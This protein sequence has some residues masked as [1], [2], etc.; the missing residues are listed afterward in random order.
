MSRSYDARRKAKRQQARIAREGATDARSWHRPRAIAVLPV[1]AIAAVLGTVGVLGFGG[2]D[3]DAVDKKEIQQ[4]VSKLLAGIPQQGPTLGSP[5]APITVW[6]LADL[7][8][9][10]VR[11]FAESYLPSILDTWVRTGEV[12]LTY[13]SLQTDTVDEEVFYRH[14]IAALAAGRQDKMWN[15]A[16]AFVHQQGE[17]FTEYATDE[18]LADLAS[19]VPGLTREQWRRD[20]QDGLLSKRVAH[21]L[22]AADNM[23]I[24]STPSFLVGVS[25]GAGNQGIDPASLASLREEVE[26]SLA[27]HIEALDEEAFKDAPTV[28][29]LGVGNP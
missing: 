24:S 12:K 28:G 13:R 23:E 11:L 1:L 27:K 10:T 8:C 6:V 19:Q 3:S 5:E 20:R 7:E 15:F 21:D 17:Q 25:P 4:T 2:G 16:L 26:F 9:P 14:Q 18:Y 22:H 29:P